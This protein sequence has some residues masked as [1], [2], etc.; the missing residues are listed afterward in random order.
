MHHQREE[1]LEAGLKARQEGLA[2]EE[3]P[4]DAREVSLDEPEYRGDAAADEGATG[5]GHADFPTVRCSPV[6]LRHLSEVCRQGLCD[7]FECLFE[8]LPSGPQQQIPHP[9]LEEIDQLLDDR[10]TDLDE[11]RHGGGP[12]SG[13]QRYGNL[14]HD[15]EGGDDDAVLRCLRVQGELLGRVGQRVGDVGTGR[16]AV[17]DT[18]S[19]AG[20]GFRGRPLK[21]VVKRRAQGCG[22]GYLAQHQGARDL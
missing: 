5:G 2:G 18:R 19:E 12:E 14:H 7:L 1:T 6:S 10:L 9:D 3:V 22:T 4:V 13:G 21:V 16:Q 15:G 11:A 17:G 20:V 8:G